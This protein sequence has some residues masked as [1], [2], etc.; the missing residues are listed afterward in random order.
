ME[1][2]KSISIDIPSPDSF[3]GID[4]NPVFENQEHQG[5]AG[6]PEAEVANAIPEFETEYTCFE[7]S[8]RYYI[9]YFFV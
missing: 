3:P 8:A 5:N 1:E 7:S 4:N 6:S 2:E 9:Y